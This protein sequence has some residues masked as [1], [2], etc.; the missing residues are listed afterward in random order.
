M[1]ATTATKKNKFDVDLPAIISN[2]IQIKLCLK[3]LRTGTSPIYMSPAQFVK[4]VSLVPAVLVR[5]AYLTISMV[6]YQ[7]Q[8]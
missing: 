7:N 1:L 5:A 6:F 8:L 2:N 4:L 3:R